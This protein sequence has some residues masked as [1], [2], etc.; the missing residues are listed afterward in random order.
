MTMLRVKGSNM[1]PGGRMCEWLCGC[2]YGG[3]IVSVYRGGVPLSQGID[4]DTSEILQIVVTALLRPCGDALVVTVGLGPEDG[5]DDEKT[6]AF[7]TT[8]WRLAGWVS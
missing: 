4:C 1:L 6:T 3:M 2:G 7:N 8:P 5:D